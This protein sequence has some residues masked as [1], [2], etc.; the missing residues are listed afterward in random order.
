[1]T[2]MLSIDECAGV[3]NIYSFSLFIAGLFHIV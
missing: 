2:R 3:M 1:M